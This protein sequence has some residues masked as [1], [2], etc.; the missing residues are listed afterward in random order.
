VVKVVKLEHV[1]VSVPIPEGVT[2]EVQE[3][4]VVIKGPKGSLERDF[5]KSGVEISV[6]DECS[7]VVVEAWYANRRLKAMVGT[8]AAHIRNM[9]KGVTQGFR[10]TMKIVYA[11]FPV[12]VKVQGNEVIIENFLGERSPRKAKIIG[13]VKITIE[14]DTIVI[15]G[16]NKEHVGQTAANIQLATKIKDKDPRVFMDGIYVASKE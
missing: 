14:G 10:Y 7:A 4:R 13:D 15:E 8:V 1:A 11:H 12:S 9:I 6:D 5:S 16:L 2:V 3:G